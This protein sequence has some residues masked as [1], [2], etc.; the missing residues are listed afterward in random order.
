[1]RIILSSS[2]IRA[3]LGIALAATVVLGACSTG[4]AA[5]SGVHVV[6]AE[7]FW[8]SLTAQ[9]AGPDASV[10]SI[11]TKPDAD[12]HD[13]EPTPSDARAFADA[14]LVIENGIGYD[15]WA[16][17]LLDADP[18]HGRV[19]LDVGKLLHVP[20]GGNPHRW[21]SRAEVGMFIQQVTADLMR[22]DPAHRN[23]YARRARD[24][25]TRGFAALDAWI[26]RIKQRFA[27]T[28]IGASESIVS[29]WADTLGLELRTP[30]SFVDAVSEG[31]EPTAADKASVDA[32]IANHAIK[33]FV[34]NEQNATPDV[35]RLVDAAH[36]ARIP[37][38]T[39][40]ETLVPETASFQEWQAREARDLYQALVEASR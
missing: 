24:L 25:T 5:T 21:Y 13:Y 2:G 9:V 39:I 34:Y 12:P 36:R 31:N 27:G 37:V 14:R 11:V 8:G 28:P 3:G 32:Q 17:R 15:P 20:D 19:V 30:Q 1:M 6:A 22:V 40:T 4:P 16:Q 23:G 26:A 35:R 29:L 33:V 10:T 7:N 38:V 18:G